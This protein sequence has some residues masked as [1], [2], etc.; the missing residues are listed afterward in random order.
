MKWYIPLLA[1]PLVGA[2]VSAAPTITAI[3]PRGLERGKP[4]E[5]VVTGTNITPETTLWLSFDAEV[6]RLPDAKP[7]PAQA[8]FQITASPKTP[9]GF[10]LARLF[11]PEGV[12]GPAAIAVDPF[13]GAAEKE[14]NNTPEKAQPLAVP[15]VMDGQCAGGDLDFYRF[16]AKKGQRL[17][18]ETEAARLG[19]G[20]VPMLRLTDDKGRFL[21]ADDTQRVL[22]DARILFTVPSDGFY[23]V[24]LSD[25][26]YRAAA[27][28]HYRLKIGEYDVAEEVFPMGFQEGRASRFTWSGGNLAKDAPWEFLIRIEP[29]GLRGPNAH[30][31]HPPAEWKEGMAWPE[32]EMGGVPH[33]PADEAAK[34]AIDPTKPLTIQGRLVKAGETHRFPIAL[35]EGVK[36]RFRVQ[37]QSLGSRLD[38]LLRVLDDKGK[39]LAQADDVDIPSLVAG[40]PPFKSA[41]P[42]LEFTAPKGVSAVTLELRDALGQGGVNHG[43]LLTIENANPDFLLR[44]Q[45][46]EVNVPRGGFAVASVAVTRRGYDGPIQ[47][48]CKDLPAG[49]KALGGFLPAK[50]NSGLLLIQAPMESPTLAVPQFPSIVGKA[51]E[52]PPLQ[53]TATLRLPLGKDANP[54]VSFMEFD[55]LAVGLDVA[56]P[57]QLTAADNV[58]LVHGLAK[59]LPVALNWAKDVKTPYPPV[60]VSVLGQGEGGKPLPGGVVFK[61]ANIPAG[62]LKAE[63]SLTAP[64]AHAEG[65]ATDLVL[66]AKT[67]VA[68]KDVTLVG[69]MVRV[70][71]KRPFE[72]TLEGKHVL[73]PGQAYVLKGTVKREAGF[74]DPIQLKVEGLPPGVTAAPIKPLPA[75]QAEFQIELKVDAKA[76]AVMQEM[77]LSATVTIGG[78]AYA[79]PARKISLEVEKVK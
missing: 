74:K 15:S 45:A 57:F 73:K 48:E 69:P 26:R 7:N 71:V 39:P 38:G 6:K 60:E 46:G 13:V 63:L 11:G 10:F 75:E 54:A 61:P 51:L 16:E 64:T 37:A 65:R 17:V 12:S 24:E 76:A 9:I 29:P 79:H 43:Y 34:A 56:S 55:R 19:A 42:V 8:R 2:A 32:I 66:Q 18:L 21:A 23:I 59:G 58:E 47:L 78:M 31:L 35:K 67:K 50:G 4:A 68:G 28:P 77:T 14:D 25:S 30:R 44:L 22:G 72:L 33:V 53:T 41:D 62:M 40:Q 3:A 20:I 70:Q 5:V 49:W 52:G 36:V 27:P 1:I